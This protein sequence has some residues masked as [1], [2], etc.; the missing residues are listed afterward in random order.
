MYVRTNHK[1][2]PP[3]A[4]T[5]TSDETTTSNIHSSSSVFS[6]NLDANNIPSTYHE[7]LSNKG[8]KKAMLEEIAALEQNNTWTLTDL[9]EGKK[10]VGSEGV[11]TIK[12]K[13]DGTIEKV[14]A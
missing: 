9:P 10:A 13:I 6:L 14:K 12:F 8:W 2:P 3:T 7:A 1:V 4:S 11:Y 5:P